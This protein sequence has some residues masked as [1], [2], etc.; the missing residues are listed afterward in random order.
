MRVLLSL[1]MLL[2][3]ATIVT[4]LRRD[5]LPGAG[6]GGGSILAVG[7]LML[8]AWLTG[9]L[10]DRIALPKISGYL[11]AGIVLGPSIAA[12]VAL[13]VLPRL[14]FASDLAIALIAL[15]AGGEIKL[16]WLRQRAA[17]LSILLV[18]DTL[19]TLAA[20]ITVMVLAAPWI[21]FMQDEPTTAVIIIA[22]LAAVVMI[23]NSPAVIIAMVSD[24]RSSGGMTQT[25]LAFAVVKDLVLIV[26]FATAMA[27]GR[28]I[29]D[30]DTAITGGFLLVVAGQLLGSIAIG[31]II[32]V[33]MAWYVEKVQV[34]LVIFVVGCCMF[35]ALLGEQAFAIGA[36]EGHLEPLLMALSAGLLMQNLW[37][38]HSQPLFHTIEQM[39]LP[40]YCLFFAVAGAK[41]DLAVF[42][43]LWY[44]S[45]GLVLLRTV[46]VWAGVTLG[47]RA[48]RMEGD[49]V[50]YLWLGLIPQAGVSL[51]LVALIGRNFEDLAWGLELTSMLIGMIVIHELLGPIGLRLALIRSGEAGR[52]G[53]KD[54][55]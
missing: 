30:E 42:A 51:V 38:R 29:L 3:V 26:L 16:G 7:L 19:F 10:F 17:Q 43:T 22:I 9:R 55:D 12:L 46:A 2:A 20:A 48:A 37:P 52:A 23:S 6:V 28:G 15:T 49:W 34:H 13:N 53:G 41:V 32:G 24:M 47:A 5:G 35:F 45:V 18:V 27:V 39:S 31:A 14:Q 25:L 1:I 44:V 50:K 11:V 4:F 8:A 21:P 36:Y 54:N 33:A 40:V